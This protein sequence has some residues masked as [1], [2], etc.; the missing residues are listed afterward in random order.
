MKPVL[1]LG[2]NGKAGRALQAFWYAHPSTRFEQVWATPHEERAALGPFEAVV[3]LWGVTP[4]SARD[5]S[6]NVT[7]AE[8]AVTLAQSSGARL[9]VH[10]SSAAVY[11]PSDAPLTEASLTEPEG[12]YGLA[13]CAMEAHLAQM[14]APPQNCILRVANLAGAESL[15]KALSSDAPITVKRFA[16]GTGPLRSYVAIPELAQVIEALV[17]ARAEALP[18]V[19]NVAAGAPVSVA[20]IVEAAGRAFDWEDAGPKD[21]RSY[22]LDTSLQDKLVTLP[23]HA[24]DAAHLVDSW[25]RYGGWA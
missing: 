9:V 1:F 12:A 7:L 18:P 22:E 4:G 21:V 2:A 19:M 16:D 14:P 11:S 5:M 8:R 15:F 17:C 10:L 23:A 13:K 3:A 20:E 24:G 6:E 25:R